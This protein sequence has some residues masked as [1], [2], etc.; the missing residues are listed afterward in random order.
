MSAAERSGG[1]IWRELELLGAELR[2][3]GVEALVVDTHNRFVGGEEGRRLA[4]QLGG[5]HVYLST[6]AADGSES[7]PV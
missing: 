4:E 1:I 6:R 5:R 3:A 7:L 2:R